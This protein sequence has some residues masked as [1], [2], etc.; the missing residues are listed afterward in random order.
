[1]GSNWF[2]AL[3]IIRLRCGMSRVSIFRRRN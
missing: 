3:R 2:R 1:M